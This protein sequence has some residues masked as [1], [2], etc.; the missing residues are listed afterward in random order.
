M[1]HYLERR[2]CLPILRRRKWT[3]LAVTLLVA[4]GAGGA[5][6]VQTPI[7]QGKAETLLQSKRSE[8]LFDPKHRRPQRSGPG[9]STS[10]DSVRGCRHRPINPGR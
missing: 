4:L 9:Q 8:S 6:L 7:Y 5:S 3:I 10:P 2:D 1:L